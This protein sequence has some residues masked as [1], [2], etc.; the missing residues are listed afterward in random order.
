M[1]SYENVDKSIPDSGSVFF[2]PTP[3]SKLEEAKNL[4]S[5]YS[6]GATQSQTPNITEASNNPTW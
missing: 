1:V 2:G 6:F 3:S 5:L 4:F